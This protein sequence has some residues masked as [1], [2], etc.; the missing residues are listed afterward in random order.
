LRALAFAAP[1]AELDTGLAG[2]ADRIL[3]A[4]GIFVDL[5][6]AVVV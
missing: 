6:V 5:A 1:G 2:A 4:H 3:V